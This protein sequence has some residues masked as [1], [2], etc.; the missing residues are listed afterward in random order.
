MVLKSLSIFSM[1]LI[2]DPKSVGPDEIQLIEQIV[3]ILDSSQSKGPGNEP[4][5]AL[6]SVLS[7]MLVVSLYYL[8]KK[9]D[10]RRV[11]T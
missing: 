10:E 4:W 9:I 7:I 11:N 2:I 1:I 6:G 8:K 3:A 5:A